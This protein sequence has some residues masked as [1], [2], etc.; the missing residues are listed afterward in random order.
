MNIKPDELKIMYDKVLGAGSNSRVYG[1]ELSQ[2]GE[3]IPVAAK[4]LLNHYVK[5]KEL[6]TLHKL[7]I[8]PQRNII[9]FYGSIQSQME[10]K[11]TIVTELA[12]ISLYDY[13]QKIKV[14]NKPLST[15]RILIWALDGAHAIQHLHDN[16]IMH[17]DIKS[18]NFL[19]MKDMTMK[20]CDF[21]ISVPDGIT[22]KTT[23]AT[24]GTTRWKAPEVW[25]KKVSH[26]SDIFSFGAVMWEMIMCELPYHE[27][28]TEAELVMAIYVNK[29][30][31]GSLPKSCPEELKKLVAECRAREREERPTIEDI[32][33]RLTILL[34]KDV[35]DGRLEL[36]TLN[37]VSTCTINVYIQTH[38]TLF[39]E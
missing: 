22:T 39:D 36:K 20:L 15:K 4:V 24:N 27:Y 38:Q 3:V 37:I 6:E 7:S 21:G 35:E 8:N 18:P 34:E 17:R 2:H 26:K 11:T 32:I 9:K 12:S 31:L 29:L 25:D 10:N 1:A 13:L 33:R 30:P 19:I 16:D 14:E 5:Q 28:Q 23:G